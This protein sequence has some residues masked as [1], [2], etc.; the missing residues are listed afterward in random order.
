MKIQLL[1][2]SYLIAFTF[3][4][5]RCQNKYEKQLISKG[6]DRI[7]QFNFESTD[8]LIRAID[9]TEYPQVYNFLMSQYIRWNNIP[10]HEQEEQTLKLYQNYITAPFDANSILDTLLLLNNKLLKAEYFYNN[11][12]LYQAFK[13]SYSLYSL[14]EPHLEDP[15]SEIASEWLL[16][17]SLYNYYYQYYQDS[18]PMLSNMM[19]L[20]EDGDKTRGLNGLTNLTKEDNLAQ[21]EALIYLSHIY[22]R[23]EDKA[24]SAYNYAKKL[25]LSY[26]ENLKFYELF[27]ESSIAVNHNASEIQPQ[28]DSLKS[29]NNVYFKKYGIT[30]DV[31]NSTE[32]NSVIRRDKL[33]NC[34]NELEQLGGGNHLKSLLYR[35]LYALTNG[36]E[37]EEYERLLI[38]TRRYNYSLTNIE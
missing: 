33:V 27:I 1:F 38:K 13:E 2:L 7:Y 35:A 34:L 36:A 30:Y 5:A 11:N 22:L 18:N 9:S 4:E 6:L 23:I 8:S 20:L 16:A 24:D 10:I 14:I 3:S 32:K 15:P 31:L 17:V 28:I 21:T 37:Q 19:W 29:S 12:Q 25:H 26:P